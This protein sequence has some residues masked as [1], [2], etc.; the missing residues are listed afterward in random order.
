[1]FELVDAEASMNQ[2]V[3]IDSRH[4]GNVPR[5]LLYSS[6]VAKPIR[7]YLVSLPSVGN[8]FAVDVLLMH[9]LEQDGV[10][11]L[12]QSQYR[13]MIENADIIAANHYSPKWADLGLHRLLELKKPTTPLITWPPPNLA[14]L[15]PVVEGYGEEAVIAMLNAGATPGDIMEAYDAMRFDPLFAFRWTDQIL[16]L[17]EIETHCEVKISDFCERNHRSVKLWFTSNHATYN[18]V[19]WMGSQLAT[20]FGVGGESEER[21]LSYPHDANGT[22]NTFPETR[23]EFDYYKFSYPMRYPRT[24]FW[25]GKEWY[26]T[27]IIKICDRIQRDRR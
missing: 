15:W 24:D 25:G 7:D 21:C 10:K 14:A 8:R 22:W 20:S 13:K 27:V 23:Y 19:A 16:R 26:K 4:G 2:Q 1:V 18:L 11:D 12:A 3:Q 6:C 17:K 5:I 9:C